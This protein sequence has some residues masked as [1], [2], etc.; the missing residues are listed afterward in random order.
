MTPN[1]GAGANVAI[2]SAAALSNSIARL[3]SSN[4]SLDEVRKV[5]KEFYLNR[6]E[7]AN[8][9]AKSANQLT[10][11]EALA[12]FPDKI[13]AL[14]VIPAL[15]DF[16]SDITCDAM[17]GAEI[18][19]NLP[20]SA[21][22]LAATMPWDPETGIG[23]H[24]NKLIRALY[25]LPLLFFFFACTKTMGPTL[26]VAAQ[27]LGS[28]REF[29]ELVLDNAQVVPLRASFFGIE[30]IDNFIAVYVAVFTPSIGG[31]DP[32]SRMQMITFLADLIPIQA[33]WMIEGV[34]RGNFLTA[35]HLL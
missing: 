4:P 12:T 32:A 7:R 19:E 3:T 18:L 30:S 27:S 8:A 26:A 2:E 22:S 28:A 15:G 14:H 13:M 10:R 17:V 31:Q 1:L 9:V 5:L 23:K 25:A 33:I 11:I 16:L 21:R 6:H 24:E 29:R 35:A 20:A 34:R